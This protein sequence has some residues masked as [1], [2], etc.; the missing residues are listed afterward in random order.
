MANS[1]PYEDFSSIF[2]HAESPHLAS[3]VFLISIKEKEYHS[4]N[5][6]VSEVKVFKMFT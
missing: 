3:S 2:F 4:R 6:N 1:Q 5:I